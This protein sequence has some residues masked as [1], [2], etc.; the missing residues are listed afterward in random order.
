MPSLSSSNLYHT[1]DDLSS[2]DVNYYKVAPPVGSA[3]ELHR[4]RIMRDPGM[5]EVVLSHM[6]V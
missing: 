6:A 5:D 3:W 4:I 1:G 2:T